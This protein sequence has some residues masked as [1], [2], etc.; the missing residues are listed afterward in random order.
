MYSKEE[1]QVDGDEA[2][3]KRRGKVEKWAK[4]A[5]R[6]CPGLGEFKPPSCSIEDFLEPSIY[7]D[8]V[9]TACKEA[10]EAGVIEKK[11]ENWETDLRNQLNTK[12]NK[13]FGKR[14]EE[15]LQSHFGEPISDVWIARKYGE[16]LR[17]G[18]AEYKPALDT[19]WND[20]VLLRLANAVWKALDLPS[21]GETKG[22][23]FTTAE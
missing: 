1:R 16:L 10:I 12:E 21:R 18:K 14:V 3:N 22:I 5:N 4:Q 15:V 8:A 6:K 7:K 11:A 20:A 19:Y 13:S 23:L 2:G 17:S 9:I